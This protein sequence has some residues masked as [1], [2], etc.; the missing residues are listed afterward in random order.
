M[1]L[2]ESLNFS[3]PRRLWAPCAELAVTA[4]P[5]EGAFR[6][7]LTQALHELVIVVLTLDLILA[8]EGH[9]AGELEAQEKKDEEA[10]LW[11]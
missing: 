4:Q 11:C 1:T 3:E 8:S 6:S 5:Q 10:G 7:S 9:A 2:H